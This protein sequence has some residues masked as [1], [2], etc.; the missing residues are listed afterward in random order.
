MTHGF[1]F[2]NRMEVCVGADVCFVVVS[3]MTLFVFRNVYTPTCVTSQTQA[4]S[5]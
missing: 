5:Q 3:Q 4:V 2:C 1:A